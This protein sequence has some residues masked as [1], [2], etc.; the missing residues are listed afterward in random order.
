[1]VIWSD[2]SARKPALVYYKRKTSALRTAEG[3]QMPLGAKRGREGGREAAPLGWRMSRVSCL[4]R[5][6]VGG[7]GAGLG[8]SPQIS[9]GCKG[10]REKLYFS[11]AEGLSSGEG[12]GI[13]VPSK[14]GRHSGG[15]R[16]KIGRAARFGQWHFERGRGGAPN[17][18]PR[19][20]FRKEIPSLRQSHAFERSSVYLEAPDFPGSVFTLSL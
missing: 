6:L 14:T 11:Y 10:R 3:A 17:L 9:Q 18:T 2:N 20:G 12:A 19:G 4:Y 8:P 7:L 5:D 13:G 15:T 16:M 1:M